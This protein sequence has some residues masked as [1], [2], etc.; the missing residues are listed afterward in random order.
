LLRKT[1]SSGFRTFIIK[2]M[3]QGNNKPK[4]NDYIDSNKLR[5]LCLQYEKELTI[6]RDYMF[7]FLVVWTLA[8]LVL[9]WL[10]F[11]GWLEHIPE[12]MSAGYIILLGAYIVHKEVGRWADLKTKVRHGEIFVYIWWGTFLIM[13][14]TAIFRGGYEVPQN[15][16]ILSYEVLGYFIF[17]EV[18]KSINRW[19]KHRRHKGFVQEA[20]SGDEG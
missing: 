1:L 14:L 20:E 15:M 10:N 6:T 18:S 5:Q 3:K 7:W 13:F 12:S 2:A 16:P 17:S 8:M 4:L 9:E 19:R 11:F